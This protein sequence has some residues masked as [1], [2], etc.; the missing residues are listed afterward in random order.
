MNKSIIID[1]NLWFQGLPLGPVC[2]GNG[3]G[4]VGPLQA[5]QPLLLGCCVGLAGNSLYQAQGSKSGIW[6]PFPTPET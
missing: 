5:R 4:L 1:W 3:Y 6:A 2:C